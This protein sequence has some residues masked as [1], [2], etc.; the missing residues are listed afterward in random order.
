MKQLSS[1]V[2]REFCISMYLGFHEFEKRNPQKVLVGFEVELIPDYLSGPIYDYDPVR[3]FLIDRFSQKHIE[4]QE[5]MA[6]IIADHLMSDRRVVCAAVKIEKPDVF[7]DVGSIG[8][9]LVCR[10]GR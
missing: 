9:K 5:E 3:L 4:T 8:F 6:Q 1:L 7:E 2:M 10:K